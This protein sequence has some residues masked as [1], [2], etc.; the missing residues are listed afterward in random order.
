MSIHFRSRIAN[1][2][3]NPTITGLD[4][5]WCC[6]TGTAVSS[7]AQ[8]PGGGYIRGAEGDSQCIAAGGCLVDLPVPGSPTLTFTDGACCHWKNNQGTYY[9][10]CEQVNND[11]DCFNLNEGT[12]ENLHS[13]F[14]PAKTCENQGGDIT[15]NG[16][17]IKNTN[18]EVCVP[19][20]NTG[21]FNS[22][23][24]IGNCCRVTTESTECII[25]T[26][27]ECGDGVWTPPYNGTLRSC[28]LSPCSDIFMP[29]GRT[30]PSATTSSVSQSTY[31]FKRIPAI[32]E[33]YQ[34][35]IYVG[36]FTENTS[37]VLGNDFTGT[38][39]TYTARGTQSNRSWILIADL[40][41][42]PISSFNTETEN[43]TDLAANEYDGWSNTENYNSLLYTTIKNHTANSFTDWY[44][45]SLDELAL[46]FK[47][48]K[49]NTVVYDN[50]NL[51]NGK[52]LTSTPFS[53]NGKQ[54]FNNNKQYMFIQSAN[55][56]DYANVS[57]LEKNKA[58]KI[59]LF[60]RIYLT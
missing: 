45:P 58:T 55:S 21:C 31:S 14:Y 24:L 32:G 23:D 41:D 57:L 27:L 50:V 26:K 52:Y 25:T 3:A 51:I 47:N 18:K 19:D 16:I 8:C 39:V 9:Q 2:N 1:N 48:I 49:L 4:S 37:E 38:A 44:L 13:T 60:R 20:D 10:T 30:P 56:S 59:R 12:S 54:S 40:Q 35:G 28:T 34:G 5:G 11:L 22:S 42:L 15:C 36:T 53:I 43:Y 46:Y 6:Q 29:T 17:K 7:P 33:Y